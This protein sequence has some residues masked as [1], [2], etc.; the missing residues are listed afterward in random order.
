MSSVDRQEK[1]REHLDK[2]LL[3]IK[4]TH[5]E[6]PNKAIHELIEAVGWLADE[7]FLVLKPRTSIDKESE[8]KNIR[9]KNSVFLV[10][11]DERGRETRS[12][13]TDIS[14]F[15]NGIV[16][17]PTSMPDGVHDINFL[18]L[19]EGTVP[20]GRIEIEEDE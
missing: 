20:Y 3:S 14:P 18:G 6:Y 5:P 12:Q 8:Q 1:F 9:A 7:V 13:I 10:L 2:A 11:I 15:G 16:I 17:K 19:L 4:D